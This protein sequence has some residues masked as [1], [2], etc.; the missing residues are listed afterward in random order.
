MS[1]E[2]REELIAYCIAMDAWWKRDDYTSE[3]CP[4]SSA[5]EALNDKAYRAYQRV[6]PAKAFSEWR[7]GWLRVAEYFRAGGEP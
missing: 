7:S 2:E 5:S 4:E 3:N 1:N 6:V